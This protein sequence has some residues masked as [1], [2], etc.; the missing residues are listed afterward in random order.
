MLQKAV[1]THKSGARHLA[2]VYRYLPVRD[3]SFL[4]SVKA[5][6][7]CKTVLLV[8]CHMIGHNWGRKKVYTNNLHLCL[9]VVESLKCVMICCRQ[10]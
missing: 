8:N 1:F 9:L 7:L 10:Y 4:L 6:S 5:L 2:K 3:A